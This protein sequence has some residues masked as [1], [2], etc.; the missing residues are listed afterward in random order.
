MG[1]GVGGG[2][3][4]TTTRCDVKTATNIV[5]PWNQMSYYIIYYS[6]LSPL[7]Y[8]WLKKNISKS[9]VT[10]VTSSI[11]LDYVVKTGILKLE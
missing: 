4:V 6:T 9:P 2:D 1:G 10:S 11:S 7:Y 5:D 8:C 3:P